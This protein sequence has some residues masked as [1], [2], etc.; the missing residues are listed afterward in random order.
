M[1]QKISRIQPE[2]RIR[3]APP[4]S[5]RLSSTVHL[6]LGNSEV[7]RLT[8]STKEFRA[9]GELKDVEGL[10]GAIDSKDLEEENPVSQRYSADVSGGIVSISLFKMFEALQSRRRSFRVL[11]KS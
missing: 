3:L 11:A 6:A 2:I 10:F 1:T 5:A 9:H 4:C 8:G 7:V